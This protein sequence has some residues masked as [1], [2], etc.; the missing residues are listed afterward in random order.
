MAALMVVTLVEVKAGST[1][2]E[3]AAEKAE[4]LAG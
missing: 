1:V 4:N 3:K 2:D